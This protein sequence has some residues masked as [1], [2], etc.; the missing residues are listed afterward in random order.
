[1]IE[2]KYL[3]DGRSRHYLCGPSEL[4]PD[5]DRY[6]EWCKEEDPDIAKAFELL[7]QQGGTNRLWL[8]LIAEGYERFLLEEFQKEVRNVIREAIAQKFNQ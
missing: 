5:L 3:G 1:M 2:F 7:Q 8:Q 4:L 6:Y